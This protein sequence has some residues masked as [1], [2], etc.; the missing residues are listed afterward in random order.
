MHALYPTQK[1]KNRAQSPIT[2]THCL[3]CGTPVRGTDTRICHILACEETPSDPETDIDGTT[4]VENRAP[5]HREARAK[6]LV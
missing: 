4:Q 2:M 3:P 5:I 6:P 1:V